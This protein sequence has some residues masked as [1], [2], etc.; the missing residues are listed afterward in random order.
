MALP[1]IPIPKKYVPLIVAVVSGLLAVFLIN[2]YIAQQSEEAKKSEEA[3]RKDLLSVMVARVDIQAGT[4]IKENMVKEEIMHKSLAQPRV[5]TS[6]DRVVDRIAL[7]PIAK[8]EQILLNKVTLSGMETSLSSKVPKGKRAITIPVDNISSVGGM[9]RP[10][11]HV[12]IVGLV[13]V[14]GLS[15]EGK[16]VTQLTSLP[17]FQDVTILA[18]GQEYTTV[19]GAQKGEKALSP[20]ITL[21][22]PPEQANLVAFVQE[23]GKIRLILRSPEDAQVQ[24]VV[25]ATWEALFRMV[26]PERFIQPPVEPPKPKKQ[27][28]IYRGLQK[29]VKALE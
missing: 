27:V 24:P 4:T 13:P 15:A 18:V 19:P 10:G 29:E 14:P 25:P 26:M 2:I 28:E 5:A 9:I 17:L 22:L 11:D 23:Q 7:A 3:R 16:Q 6:M 20:I 1:K 12:D 8:G 21:A